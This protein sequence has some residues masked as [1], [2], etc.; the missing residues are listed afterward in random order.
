MKSLV[1]YFGFGKVYTYKSFTEFKCRSFTD[2]LEKVIPF[3]LKFPIPTPPRSS[4]S[5]AQGV[6]VKNPGIFLIDV[7]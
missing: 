3:F 4:A 6:K 1:D 2:N 5:L 7:K